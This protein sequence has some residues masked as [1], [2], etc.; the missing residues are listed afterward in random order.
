[1]SRAR[2][3]PLPELPIL[4]SLPVL[5]PGTQAYTCMVSCKAK[6]CKYYSLSI[7]TPR[8]AADFDDIRWYLMHERTNVYKYEG[9]W[10]LLVEARCRHL[11]PENA[12]GIYDRRPRTCADYDPSACEY[13]GD[14][15]YDLYFRDD[16]ELETWLAQRAA[17]RKAARRPRAKAAAPRRKPPVKA[18]A[19]G[20]ARRGRGRSTRSRARAT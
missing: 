5:Q 20:T 9:V 4:P 14:V 2:T 13:T 8:S 12:C 17:K 15:P 1:M 7:D 18:K 6:C 11:T 19:T 10:Y 16:T 3:R